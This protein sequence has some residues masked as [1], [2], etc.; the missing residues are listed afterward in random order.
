MTFVRRREDSE[1]EAVIAAALLI[2]IG[3]DGVNIPS[4]TKV[5][6]DKAPTVR[7]TSI[8][9]TA[10]KRNP[11]P[12]HQRTG[13]AG[14]PG[15]FGPGDDSAMTNLPRFSLDL[16]TVAIGLERDSSAAARRRA[17]WLVTQIADVFPDSTLEAQRELRH[18]LARHPIARELFCD[19]ITR[20]T[21]LLER[22]ATP[23]HLRRALVAATLADRAPDEHTWTMRVRALAAAR[24]EV[25]AAVV[26]VFWDEAC[27]RPASDTVRRLLRE[28]N[29]RRRGAAVRV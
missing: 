8:Q 17:A 28:E 13:P 4:M 16:E 22:D 1:R 14:R 23:R 29:E 9:Q 20:A 2:E 6:K 3:I 25:A 12:T 21:A 10:K 27:E 18:V 11:H 24:T 19:E 15:P 26:D 7:A 5:E